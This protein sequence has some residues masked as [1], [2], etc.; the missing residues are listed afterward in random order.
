MSFLF[1]YVL[2]IGKFR[3]DNKLCND[4]D[5]SKRQNN[6]FQLAKFNAYSQDGEEMDDLMNPATPITS[7]RSTTPSCS[8]N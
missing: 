2:S 7:V 6:D 8:Y 4:V 1:C 3:E 5:G